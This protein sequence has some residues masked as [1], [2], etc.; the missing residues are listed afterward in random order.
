MYRKLK[1]DLGAEDDTMADLHRDIK[2]FEYKIEEREDALE[3]VA[4]SNRQL[5]DEY[6]EKLL[7]RSQEVAESKGEKA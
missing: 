2:N 6:D 5:Q 4:E 1:R 7:E 3:I